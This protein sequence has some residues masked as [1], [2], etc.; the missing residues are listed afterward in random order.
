MVSV[1]W[2][3]KSY[4][5]IGSDTLTNDNV[6]HVIITK[7]FTRRKEGDGELGLVIVTGRITSAINKK[8]G[9]EGGKGTR[10]SDFTTSNKQYPCI[11]RWMV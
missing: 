9:G 7:S 3:Y 6:E 4:Y 5:I 8:R 10:Y 11:F 2:W 1:L